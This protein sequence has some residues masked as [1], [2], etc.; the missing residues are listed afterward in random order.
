VA[1]LQDGEVSD[2][3]TD[4]DRANEFQKNPL[5]CGE[6]FNSTSLFLPWLDQEPASIDSVGDMVSP[7]SSV[8]LPLE[9]FGCSTDCT[10]LDVP[11]VEQLQLSFSYLLT[12]L[13][14]FR[15]TLKP[16]HSGL[17][18]IR[19][20]A[21]FGLSAGQQELSRSDGLNLSFAAIQSEKNWRLAFAA[22]HAEIPTRVCRFG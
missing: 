13:P 12:T 8:V 9:Q 15:S 4:L 2:R 5:Q 7:R 20:M 22:M 10:R 17:T 11:G 6:G 3:G 19:L 21:A 14:R 18:V 16:I 1:A